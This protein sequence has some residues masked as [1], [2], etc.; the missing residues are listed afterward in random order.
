MPYKIKDEGERRLI[1][2]IRLRRWVLEKG[3]RLAR[4][5]GTSFS[6]MVEKALVE[7]HK[8]EKGGQE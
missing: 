8:L 1:A 4:V 7:V 6:K 5:Q 2:C 3:Q